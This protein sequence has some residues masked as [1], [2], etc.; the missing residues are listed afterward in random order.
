[1][2]KKNVKA[3]FLVAGRLK[4]CSYT[5]NNQYLLICQGTYFCV[6]IVE[7][8]SGKTSNFEPSPYEIG[9][10]EGQLQHIFVNKYLT[11]GK[12]M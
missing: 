7:C 11:D 1:M 4:F 12:K 9:K 8:C 10:F 3:L 5:Q 2:R 6:W